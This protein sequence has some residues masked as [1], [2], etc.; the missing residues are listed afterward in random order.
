MLTLDK[1]EQMGADA[2]ARGLSPLECPFFFDT[3]QCHAWMDGY[4]TAI[5]WVMAFYFPP[6]TVVGIEAIH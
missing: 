1:C 2:A 5:D 4:E 6:G 3:E